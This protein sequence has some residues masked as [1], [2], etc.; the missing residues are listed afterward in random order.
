MYLKEKWKL[1]V[2]FFK[3]FAKRT[4]IGGPQWFQQSG[5][6]ILCCPRL[7]CQCCRRTQS[8]SRTEGNITV[9]VIWSHEVD[10]GDGN[11]PQGWFPFSAHWQ[12]QAGWCGTLLLGMSEQSEITFLI[13][14]LQTLA[15]NGQARV[16]ACKA[17]VGL[18]EKPQTQPGIISRRIVKFS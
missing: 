16:F 8:R 6:P 14:H 5:Q 11:K 1:S 2:F 18:G 17:G 15:C 10:E 7:L 9:L 13:D 4:F 12:V 3:R